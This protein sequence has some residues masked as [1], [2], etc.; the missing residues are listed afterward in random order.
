VRQ[1][2]DREITMAAL[3]SKLIDFNGTSQEVVGEV[4]RVATHED[5]ANCGVDPN[6]EFLIVDFDNKG[7]Q[8]RG[9]W[10]RADCLLVV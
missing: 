3:A 6:I 4:L 10:K 2:Y 5:K 9:I 1:P 7:V 8:F